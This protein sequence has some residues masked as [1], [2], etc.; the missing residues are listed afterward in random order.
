MDAAALRYLARQKADS[1]LVAE[2][3]VN[4]KRKKGAGKTISQDLTNENENGSSG[5]EDTEDANHPQPVKKKTDI[6]INKRGTLLNTLHF[7]LVFFLVFIF[8]T[9]RVLSLNFRL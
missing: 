8:A 5:E 7:F 4:R 1:D 3:R 2:K 6:K 9:K